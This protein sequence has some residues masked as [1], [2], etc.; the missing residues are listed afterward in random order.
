MH[1]LVEKDPATR[2]IKEVTLEQAEELAGRF[3]IAVVEGEVATPWAEW[4]A[5][6]KPAK[7]KKR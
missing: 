2:V 7:K 4:K 3:T 5:Q 6:Q 1:V